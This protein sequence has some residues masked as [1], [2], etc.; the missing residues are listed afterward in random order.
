MPFTFVYK[1][2]LTPNGIASIVLN[3]GEKNTGGHVIRFNSILEALY[4]NGKEVGGLSHNMAH[5]SG[6]VP[7][8]TQPIVTTVIHVESGYLI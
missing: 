3:L 4:K 5:G 1:N 7:S 2:T 8:P 6:G